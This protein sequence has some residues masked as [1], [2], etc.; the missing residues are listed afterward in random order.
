MSRIVRLVVESRQ[1]KA[2][3][4]RLVDRFARFY[5]PIVISLA[6]LTAFVIP[7]IVG[8]SF[9][10]WL[11]RSLILLVV[12][13]P[14]AFLISVPATMFMAVAIAAR[15]GVI[16]KGGVYVEKLA[17][18]KAVVFDKTGTLTLGEPS[19]H[20]VNSVEGADNRALTYAAALEQYSN[21]PLARTIVGKAAERNL[22]FA[23]LP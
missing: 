15:R 23:K 4:E 12:S 11:Y 3:V 1:R 5:I 18:I 21:H 13:C 22:D 20:N 19:V 14:S 7:R 16:V 17:R 9:E 8:G 6:A 10:S 2:S